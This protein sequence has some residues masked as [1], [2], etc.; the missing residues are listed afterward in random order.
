MSEIQDKNLEIFSDGSF[1][2][3]E[4]L[5]QRL[6]FRACD[7]VFEDSVQSPLRSVALFNARVCPGVEY[8][9]P[10][11]KDGLPHSLTLEMCDCCPPTVTRRTHRVVDDED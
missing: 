1:G 11:I 5:R 9:W 6:P 10:S 2:I 8:E 7:G 3:G 4:P